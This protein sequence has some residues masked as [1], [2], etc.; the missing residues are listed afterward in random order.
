[1]RPG[2]AIRVMWVVIS[3]S[4]LVRRAPAGSRADEDDLERLV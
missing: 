3:M 1:M 2:G 4:S